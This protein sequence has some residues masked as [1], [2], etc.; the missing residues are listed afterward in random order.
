MIFSRANLCAVAITAKDKAIGILNN[1]FFG[2]D[3]TTVG[4]H[5]KGIMVVSPVPGETRN[6][7]PLEGVPMQGDLVIHAD[8]VREVLR[9]VKK[10]VKFGG[11]LEHVDL[12]DGRFTYTDGARTHT[13][14]ALQYG[15]RYVDWRAD[16]RGAL[17]G[18]GV[19]VVVNRRRLMALLDAMDRAC[20]D[21]SDEAALFM[22]VGSVVTLRALNRKTG[23][24]TIGVMRTYDG[25]E[26]EWLEDGPWEH[27]LM[28]CADITGE[29]NTTKGSLKKRVA[30]R[31]E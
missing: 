24:R 14:A 10:D 7:V 15:R 27:S 1:V 4:A 31:K 2:R 8:S 12:C 29:T 5:S 6:R 19:R 17:S 20:P 18:G 3:G 26:G 13:I 11:L 9:N 28:R 23:Q 22:E 16:V 30:R 21:S 25:A